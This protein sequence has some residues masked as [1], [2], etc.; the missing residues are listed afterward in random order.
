MQLTICL[1]ASVHPYIKTLVRYLTAYV[2][3]LPDFGEKRLLV[4]ILDALQI[5][6]RHILKVGLR[7]N[8]FKT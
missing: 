6:Q 4:A 7:T 2:T 5:W 3:I 1:E 8:T